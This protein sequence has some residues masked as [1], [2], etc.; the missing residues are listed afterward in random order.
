[1]LHLTGQERKPAKADLTALGAGRYT[2]A[3]MRILLVNDDGILAAGLAGLRQAVGDMGEVR[4]VAPDSPQSAAG[5][6]ITVHT[7][8]HCQR[9]HAD[10]AFW[11][12]GVAGSP[13]D[14]VKLAVRQLMDAPPDLVLA[15][16]NAGANV[17]VNVFYSGTVAAAAEGALFGIP[18]VA[19]S[20]AGGG[21]MD[22]HRAGRLC[23]WV[24]EGLLAAPIRPGE[25][26]NVNIPA[27]NQANPRGVKVVAQSTA[28]INETYVRESDAEG[29]LMFRLTDAYEHGP[30]HRETD[31]TALAEGFITITPLHCD[32]TDQDRLPALGAGRWEN[33]P[34]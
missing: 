26:I 19:F 16:I 34:G 25:L 20:L 27:L 10:G 4:V 3:G 23:R 2:A 33:M 22:F 24:L 30:Q 18:S 1:M 9:V 14:C 31:V 29:R 8:I 32:L 28:A 17:G 21:E 7:P 15:G 13:A 11:G 12:I 6:S 5:R